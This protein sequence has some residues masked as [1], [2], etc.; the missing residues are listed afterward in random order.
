LALPETASCEVPVPFCLGLLNL[1]KTMT[2]DLTT[3]PDTELS[4]SASNAPETLDETL[5]AHLHE[6][7]S[8]STIFEKLPTDLRRRLDQAIID[9]DPPSYRA[10]HAKFGLSA[11]GVSFTALYRYAR[12][13]RAQADLLHVAHL[14]LPDAPDVAQS[15]PTLLA[16]RLL[17]ALNNEDSSPRLLHRLVDAWRIAVNAKLALDHEAA[18]LAEVRR[19]S[20]NQEAN[21]LFKAIHDLTKLRKAENA[22]QCRA[23]LAELA[24]RQPT[25]AETQ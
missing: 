11:H 12:R 16:Y 2:D 22:A 5:A 9:R 18:D 15:L 20:K 13:L 19:R 25:S 4:T 17:D 6:I 23:A 7:E 10:L 14:A 21:E 24:A 8:R 1:E 3:A